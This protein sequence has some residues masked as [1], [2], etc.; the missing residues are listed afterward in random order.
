MTEQIPKYDVAV[1]GAGPAGIMAA[2]FAARAGRKVVLL[3][4]NG[5]IGRKILA[6]GNGRCNLTNKNI[7]VSKYHGTDPAFVTP[8]FSA[9]NQ[10]QTM[11]F[12]EGLGAVLKE[13]DRGRIF[14]RT[15]Q[16]T[17]I[18]EALEHEL[19]TQKVDVMTGFTV[20][21]IEKADYWTITN[22]SS[23]I[24][25]AKKLILTTGGKAAHQ[26]GS[27]G[28]GLFWARNL[29]HNVV[30]IHAALVPLEVSESW[31]KEL[32]GIKLTAYVQLLA[33][34]KVVATRDGDIIFTHFGISGPAVMGLA[35]EVEPILEAKQT[36]QISID[37]IP[38]ITSEKL[39][40]MIEMQITA[41]SK[42][43]IASI[44]TGFVPKNLVPRILALSGIKDDIKAAE[45]SKTNRRSITQTL[46]DFRL[47]VSKVCPLKEAQVTAG[48]VSTSEVSPNLESKIIS[49]LYFGGEILDIDGDSGGFNLQWAWSSGAV[50]GESASK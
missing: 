39:D 27:S 49:D 45:I 22:E 28:D 4:K 29:G 41:N 48:G 44:V 7:D 18:V 46:K 6:T 23:D 3:E 33:D 19:E 16:A 12:F 14:P 1:I 15:N 10:T 30:P 40:S 5:K 43:L 37:L 20:K 8:I 38:D 31:V 13:E 47:T 2:I 35:R 42:K 26:F 11:E 34:G 25:T 9:F 32:M 50:A 36:A 21:K 24:I 17:T